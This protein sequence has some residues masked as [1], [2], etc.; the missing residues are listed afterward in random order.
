MI[1][2]VMPDAMTIGINDALIPWRW[3]NPKEMLER[4]QTEM[5]NTSYHRTPHQM[6]RTGERLKST[7]T[8]QAEIQA[9]SEAIPTYLDQ[10]AT[11]ISMAEHFSLLEDAF[12]KE[13]GHLLEDPTKW[14]SKIRVVDHLKLG[15][16]FFILQPH[17]ISMVSL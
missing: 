6:K 15:A 12:V 14:N 9:A 8:G 11:H 2:E 13:F 5:L 3:G 16:A 17:R 7:V 10:V 4:L 1:A